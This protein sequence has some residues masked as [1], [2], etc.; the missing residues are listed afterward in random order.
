MARPRE[1][2]AEALRRELARAVGVP[3]SCLFLTHGASEGN[4][5]VLFYLS[6]RL[7]TAGNSRPTVFVRLPEYPPLRNA[8]ELSGF[9][10]VRP[11]R[12]ADLAIQSDPQNPT[13]LSGSES[14]IEELRGR[15]RSILVDEAFRE[16]S[17]ARSHARH[18]QR[19][20]WTTG[21]FTKAYGGDGIRV[22][23]VTAPDEEV[24]PFEAFHGV[25]LN[26]LADASVGA[27]RALLRDRSTILR[28]TRQIVAAN[29]RA[30]VAT[31]PE[32]SGIQA[33]LW[34]DRISGKDGDRF[35]RAL[36]RRSVLVCP[37]SFF[38]VSD[39]V[40]LCLTRRSF[41]ADLEAYLLARSEW[42]RT[43]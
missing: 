15:A 23:F 7:R 26:G 25:L 34:F 36:L 11:G 27:A 35:A 16:F 20:L 21:T 30:L 9:S 3:A 22:G 39:G 8:A 28:E 4:T 43:A 38:G 40:R 31:F 10:P 24:E 42:L 12:I 6:H 5:A 2:D 33:P 13:G 19:G 29:R 18:R 37:G 17:T 1:P 32:A 41:P 14:A